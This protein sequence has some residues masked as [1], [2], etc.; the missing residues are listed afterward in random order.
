MTA[1]TI[2][3]FDYRPIKSKNTKKCIKCHAMGRDLVKYKT[4]EKYKQHKIDERKEVEEFI[5]RQSVKH[6][7]K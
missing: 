5:D 6:G 2:K 4:C 7:G 1:H 3:I